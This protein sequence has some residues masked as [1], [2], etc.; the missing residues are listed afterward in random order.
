MHISLI[1]VG[2]LKSG[3]EKELSD[4]YASRFSKTGTALGFRSFRLVEVS[5]GGGL[6]A[7]GKRLAEK[8]PSGAVVIRLDEFG[9]ERTSKAFAKDLAKRRDKGTPHLCFLIGGAEGYSEAIRTT[10]PDTLALGSQTWP[11]RLVRVMICEQLYRAASLLAGTPYHK[12]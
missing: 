7:E 11:H 12:A 10:Y 4:D 6:D 9:A 5:S 8:V 3:P 2:K 1:C